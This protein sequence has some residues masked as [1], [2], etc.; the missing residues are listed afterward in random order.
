[1]PCTLQKVQANTVINSV[2]TNNTILQSKNKT[3]RFCEYKPAILYYWI[4]MKA[5]QQLTDLP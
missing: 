5:V 3:Y 4:T 2:H 1:M